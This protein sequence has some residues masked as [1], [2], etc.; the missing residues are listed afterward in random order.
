MAT[1]SRMRGT[2]NRNGEARC[3][4]I[5][6]RQMDSLGIE[7]RKMKTTDVTR[8]SSPLVSI[9]IVSYNTREMTLECL[10][11]VFA[12]TDQPF[13]VILVD[14]ASS[15][16][17]AAAIAAE[18]PG[19]RLMAETENHGFAKANNLAARHACG[20]YLL[21]LNPDTVVLDGAIDRLIDF[22]RRAP[23]AGIWGGRTLYGDSSVNPTN[24]WGRMTLWSVGSQVLGLS[25]LF[26]RS[27]LF[28]PEGYGS[29]QRDSERGVDIV[30]GCFLLIRKK[31]WDELEGFNLS[32]VMYGEEADLCLRARSKGARP[33]ITPEAQ[34]VHYAGASET[35]RSD[36]MV[37][38]L[39]AKLLLIRRH[40]P[41]WQR[42]IGLLLFR[43]WPLTRYWATRILGRHLAAQTWRQ[44]WVRRGE[45]WY[46][47][48]E[49]ENR[50]TS[51]RG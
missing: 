45:W 39:R 25:S 18:F 49:I 8:H 14:N 51:G 16:G 42:P 26:R 29:W 23:E 47:W 30:T 36:K 32:F 1:Q 13:E 15:D 11:S 37:R 44:I 40:F 38:L 10:R 41:A 34:I 12:Q 19:I 3:V 7:P 21:L 43:L 50:P 17:S 35:V 24:C 9:I 27:G 2:A 28:N 31:F 5:E 46:G 48:P 33:R 6:A 22:A 20:E 4:E